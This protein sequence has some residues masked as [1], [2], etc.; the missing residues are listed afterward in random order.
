M[1]STGQSSLLMIEGNIGAGKSTFLKILKKHLDVDII[2]E[3]TD[4]WQNLD[5]QNN[6]LNLFYKDTK[7]WAYTFQSYAFISRIQTIL[8][9]QKT[10]PTGVQFLE[11]SIY[12][13]RY[14]FAKNC[15]E[16][17]FMT[18]LEWEVYKEWFAWLAQKYAPRPSGFIYL[19]TDPQTCYERIAKRSRHEESE[20]ALEYLQKLHDRHEDW[21]VSQKNVFSYLQ[22]VP[23][24]ILDCNKE[25]ENDMQVQKE[26][27]HK[28]REFIDQI[29]L[30]SLAAPKQAM[31]TNV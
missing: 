29:I 25:F 9:Y 23:V 27:M 14:C 2:F 16:T 30:S 10:S 3:P 11:R 12:C 26:H 19:Q 20:V 7:R 17:G 13:D 22:S 1:S 24:L 6:L 4:K 5:D 8:E 21:L 28:I 18:K 31:Q 15:Y